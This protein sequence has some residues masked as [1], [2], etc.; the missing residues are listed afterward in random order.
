MQLE[1]DTCRWKYMHAYAYVR[2]EN[3]R[4]KCLTGLG[5][6][7]TS[8]SLPLQGT[9]HVTKTYCVIK[10]WLSAFNSSFTSEPVSTSE[11]NLLEVSGNFSSAY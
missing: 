3:L 6:C 4:E 10:K 5:T 1:K 8:W 9:E 11:E 7:Q 2:L